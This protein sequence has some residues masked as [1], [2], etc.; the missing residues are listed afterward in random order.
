[1]DARQNKTKLSMGQEGEGGRGEGAED[2]KEHSHGVD[3]IR[4]DNNYSEKMADPHIMRDMVIT[5]V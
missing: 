1:M 3:T 5:Y 4:L 2:T